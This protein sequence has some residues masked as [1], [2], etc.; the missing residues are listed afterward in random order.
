MPSSL[1]AFIVALAAAL[2]G[3]APAAAALA[4]GDTRLLDRPS[5]DGALPNDLN[6]YAILAGGR[7]MSSDGRF[8]VFES[9]GDGLVLATSGRRDQRYVFVRDRQT[10]TVENVCRASAG[11]PGD[12]GCQTAT[13][14]P[15]GRY[16]AFTSNSTNLGGPAAPLRIYVHDRQTDVTTLMSRRT[17]ANGAVDAGFPTDPSV[18]DNGTV[19]FRTATSLDAADTNAFND[20][21]VR[22]LGGVTRLLSK[23][24]GGTVGNSDS[25][26][27]DISGDGTLVAFV[28]RAS[29]LSAGDPNSLRDI[30]TATTAGAGAVLQSRVGINGAV[31]DAT[32][33]SPSLSQVGDFVAFETSATNL[34]AGDLNGV[35][36]IVVR[37]LGTGINRP[38]S[39]VDGTT[40][41]LLSQES[42]SP[43][44]AASGGAVAFSVENNSVTSKSSLGYVR[45]LT[46]SKRSTIVTRE[47]GPSGSPLD[48]SA[49]GVTDDGSR[50]LFSSGEVDGDVAEQIWVRDLAAGANDR[51]SRPGVADLPAQVASTTVTDTSADGRFTT[52]LSYSS[53]LASGPVRQFALYVRDERA[54]TTTRLAPLTSSATQFGV[55]DARISDDGGTVVFEAY[56]SGYAPG[57]ETGDVH[58]YVWRRATGQVVVASRAPDGTPVAAVPEAGLDVSADGSKLAFVSQVAFLPGDAGTDADVFVRDLASGAVQ[59]ASLTV[60]G[61]SL[62]GN[63]QRPRLDADG[64][65]V[66]FATIEK[67]DPVAD[68]NAFTDIYVRDL[69]AGVTELVSRKDGPG[70]P[71]GDAAAYTASISA[72]GNRVAFDTGAKDYGAGD[73]TTNSDVFVRDRSAGRTIWASRTFDGSQNDGDLYDA[74][75]S[76]DGRSVAFAGRSTKL[77]PTSPAV[78]A[79]YVR[80]LDAPAA[81]LVA[82]EGGS[83]SMS[84]FRPQLSA[85]GQ[86]LAFQSGDPSLVPGGYTS[87][88]YQHVYL[89]ALGAGCLQ[90]DPPVASPV[91]TPSAA[92][93]TTAPVLSGLKVSRKVFASRGKRGRGTVVSLNASEAVTA[94][95][96]IASLTTGKRKGKACLKPSKVKG[97]AKA[98]VL[99]GKPRLVRT[100]SLGA[101]KRTI[102]FDGTVGGK[103]LRAGRYRLILTATD[104]AGNAMAKRVTVDVRVR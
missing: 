24:N 94:R 21:Y 75:L 99:E 26:S 32:S 57:D 8:V 69:A 20:V 27:P 46:G 28:S 54:G 2:V 38:A 61:A 86:C 76:G 95:L 35:R 58:V 63:A 55:G 103:R 5:G 82:V 33:E 64:S 36:D 18:A 83:P 60:A 87:P 3:A 77:L 4:P 98:C 51:V 81:Q 79:L 97:R 91:P 40:S 7:A 74:S 42:Y 70:T 67:A 44:L 101:G 89:R 17:G 84:G 71:T 49:R 45:D 50:A 85:S 41:T 73:T 31:G 96:E 9:D 80:V 16:V 48:G 29:N 102:N 19:A 22:T 90:D 11:E 92:K 72:D 52:F 13:I 93:D 43:Q 56:G 1:R 37:E 12:K 10:G 65:V 68:T 53:G 15:N 66:T 100:V 39:V 6:G 104:A 14:S 78:G 88:D 23:N 25:S 62:G 47:A 59:R 30:Y 34:V